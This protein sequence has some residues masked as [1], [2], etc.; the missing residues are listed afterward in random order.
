MR[1]QIIHLFVLILLV[2]AYFPVESM[3]RKQ[4]ETHYPDYRRIGELCRSVENGQTFNEVSSNTYSLEAIEKGTAKH[5]IVSQSLETLEFAIDEQTSFYEEVHP[6]FSILFI[7]QDNK[8]TQ[9]SNDDAIQ[10]TRDFNLPMPSLGERVLGFV[11]YSFFS[12][13]LL[14]GLLSYRNRR[15]AG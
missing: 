13:L 14:I 7:F 9:W 2:A 3:Y 11:A 10:T 1:F 12:A 6:A 5:D 4:L 8:L 15:K